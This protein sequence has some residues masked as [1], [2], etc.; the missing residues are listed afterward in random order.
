MS[1]KST[2]VILSLL[3]ALAAYSECIRAAN[4]VDYGAEHEA[5]SIHCLDAFLNSNIRGISTSHSHSRN[6]SAV[7]PT[8][9]GTIDRVVPGARFNDHPFRELFS[10]QDLFRFEKVY[11]L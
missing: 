2:A 9:G 10:D 1:R 4:H 7:L 11:R 5:P 8:M 3:L 6:L